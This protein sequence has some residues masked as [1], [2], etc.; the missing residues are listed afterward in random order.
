[1]PV[2]PRAFV[3]YSRAD[4][5]FALRLVG[6]LKSAG[7]DVWL[8]QLDIE[9]GTPW[10]S[11]IEDALISSGHLLVILSTVSVTSDNVRDEIS[12]AL[13]QQMKVIPVLY[14]DCKV[15]FRLARLEHIDFRTDYATALK[16]L[17]RALRITQQPPPP[18]PPLEPEQK[19]LDDVQRKLKT[20][21][22]NI[23]KVL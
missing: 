11:A 9:P 17:L 23:E 1:V 7:A 21:Q 4:S 16:H 20:H 14:Q 19:R 3:S 22:E 10:D 18:P 5:E 13:G 12:Y 15:P 2:S 6:D 8:D